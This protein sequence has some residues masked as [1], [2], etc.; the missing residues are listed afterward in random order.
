MSDRVKQVM[1]D[2]LDLDPTSIGRHTAMSNTEAWDSLS[3]VTLCL[4]LE[5]AFQVTLSVGDMEAMLSYEDIVRVLGA[6][7]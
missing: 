7:T 1:A 3:H 6:K 2:V 5:E 4:S